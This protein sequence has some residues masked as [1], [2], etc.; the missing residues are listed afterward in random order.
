MTFG[1]LSKT[2]SFLSSR[3]QS[4][5]SRKFIGINERELE[6]FLK[7]LV[8]YAHNERLFSH[9]IYSEI[10]DTTL[11]KKLCIPKTGTQYTMGKKDLFSVIIT[12][13]YMLSKTDFII[14]KR[15][16]AK[17]IERYIKKS[18]RISEGTLL[19]L[20]GFPSN[21]KKITQYKI[22]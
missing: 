11:H 3:V 13:R 7:V 10:P 8:L 9:R 21:W 15:K 1:Q 2:Y 4:K 5:I 18:Q 19:G 20:I 16:L 22:G 14:F 6:Q 12:F 17:M